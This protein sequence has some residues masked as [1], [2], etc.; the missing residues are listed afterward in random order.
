MN[1]NQVELIRWNQNREANRWALANEIVVC[2]LAL[3]TTRE[4]GSS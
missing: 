3:P 2:A 4:T 1:I